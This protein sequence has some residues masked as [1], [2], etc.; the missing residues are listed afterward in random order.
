[1]HIFTLKRTLHLFAVFFGFQQLANAQSAATSAKTFGGINQYNTWSIG[2]NVGAT[3]PTLATG[4]TSDFAG[5]VVA[6]GYGLSIK[7]QLAY[8]FALQFDLNGGQVAGGSTAGKPFV[9]NPAGLN[10]VSYRTNYWQGAISGVVNVASVNY[11]RRENV[12]NFYLSGGLGLADYTPTLVQYATGTQFKYPN[13]V[14]NLVVPIGGGV[15]FKATDAI[16]LNFGYTIN[17]IDGDNLDGVNAQFPTNDH[18]S[19]GYAGAEFMLGSRLKKNLEWVNPVARMYDELYDAELRK[20]V[21]ALKGRITNVE[22]AIAAMKKDAD[23]DGV[24]DMFDKCPNTPAGTIVD[25]AGCPIKMPP[26]MDISGFELKTAMVNTM[27][28]DLAYTNIQFEFDSF[29]LKVSSYPAL[30]ATATALK[31]SGTNYEIDGF[32]SSEG[33]AAHNIKLSRDR[34]NSVKAYLINSGVDARKLKIKAYGETHPLA[35]N[36][37][38]EGR[39]L[40]RR[41]EFKKL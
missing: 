31:T 29:A 33:T 13:T 5:N 41:V 35:N 18:Y 3:S 36:N 7:K 4:G 8:S 14:S 9:T 20:E 34:A 11:L 38:E 37:T 16:A 23:G 25:G 39:V 15:R 40:N 22:N 24:S 27:P 1:M 32:A 28:A 10:F 6:L 26:P 17:F 30:D 21:A 2:L 12:I 19:Y